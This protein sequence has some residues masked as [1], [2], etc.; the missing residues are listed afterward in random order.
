MIENL[1]WLIGLILNQNDGGQRNQPDQVQGFLQVAG[2]MTG[3]SR[4]KKNDIE[5]IGFMLDEFRGRGKA[6]NPAAQT[7]E[8]LM[9][10]V[11]AQFEMIDDNGTASTERLFL[12]FDLDNREIEPE[13]GADIF[14]GEYTDRTAQA[15]DDIF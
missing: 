5:V 1:Q 7:V 4:C 2:M 13:G 6:V 3:V 10:S 9:E 12:L 11:S 8:L 14:P 15:F